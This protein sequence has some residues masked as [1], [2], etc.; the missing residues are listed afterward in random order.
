MDSCYSSI[1]D[2]FL[3]DMGIEMFKFIKR[4]FEGK[5]LTPKQKMMSS[6]F[7]QGD[8]RYDNLWWQ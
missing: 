2:Y 3:L 7:S 4:L 6:I 1:R 5:E 8:H